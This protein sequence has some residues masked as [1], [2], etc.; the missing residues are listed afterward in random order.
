MTEQGPSPSDVPPRG[1]PPGSTSTG[2]GSPGGQGMQTQKLDIGGAFSQIFETYRGQATILLPAAV[3]LFLPVAIFSGLAQ[4]S[5]ASAIVFGLISGVLSLLAL[6]VYQGMVVEAVRDFQDGVRDVDMGALFRSA[7]PFIAPLF[8]A[9]ILWAIGIGIGFA[10]LV[11]PGVI[12]LTLWAVIA[13]SIV[14]EHRGVIEAFKRS[15][16]LVRGNFWQVLA[17]IVVVALAQFVVSWIL[18]AIINAFAA[19]VIGSAVASLLANA[20]IAPI[21]A[22]AATVMFLNLRVLRGEPAVAAGVGGARTG[23]GPGSGG[24]AGR[25][26]P[27]APTSR[28]PRPAP[29][30]TEPGSTP[31]SPGRPPTE[32]GGRP[33][34]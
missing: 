32:P 5:L 17:V 18:S 23:A 34:E 20:V 13:P 25:V 6:F 10:L 9:G 33:L 31:S 15:Q 28:P 16:E 27:E 8:G 19:S 14:L 21:S 3:L 12:L 26:P 4:G 22:T 11:V 29:G 1:T 24:G 2:V 30:P 7:T